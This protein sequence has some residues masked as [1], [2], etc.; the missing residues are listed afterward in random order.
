[1][2]AQPLISIPRRQR[3]KDLCEFEVSQSYIGSL[4]LKQTR[5]VV[6]AFNTTTPEKLK[7]KQKEQE[8]RVTSHRVSIEPSLGY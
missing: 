8:L 3:H 4:C 5:Q 1:M 7:L 6:Q 2:V